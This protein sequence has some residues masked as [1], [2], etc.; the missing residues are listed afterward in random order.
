[1]SRSRYTLLIN[2]F[3]DWFIKKKIQSVSRTSAYISSSCWLNV[4]YALNHEK[5]KNDF[6][7]CKGILKSPGQIKQVGFGKNKVAFVNI[8]DERKL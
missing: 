2:S 8:L 1:M 5:E 7:D 4:K 6:S 3:I